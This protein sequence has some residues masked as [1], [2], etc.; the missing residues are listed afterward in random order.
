MLDEQMARQEEQMVR[1]EQAATRQ[2]MFLVQ[3]CM[4]CQVMALTTMVIFF[5]GCWEGLADRSS[6]QVPDV[7][8]MEHHHPE[9][10][11]SWLS[12]QKAADMNRRCMMMLS[13]T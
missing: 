4:T 2:V 7:T 11:V 6:G 13:L 12:L 3:P 9:D 5:S 8:T 10:S 1:Q